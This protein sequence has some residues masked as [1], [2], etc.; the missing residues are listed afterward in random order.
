[1]KLGMDTLEERSYVRAP[2]VQPL[3]LTINIQ[4]VC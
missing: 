2:L 3:K 1:M 4:Q